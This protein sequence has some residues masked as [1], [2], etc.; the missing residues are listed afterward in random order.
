MGLKDIYLKIE[1][2]WFDLLDFLD[3][4]GLPVYTAIDPLEK[5]GIPSLP[6]FLS[7]LIVIILLANILFMGN[8]VV[9]F[10]ITNQKGE[11]IPATLTLYDDNLNEINTLVTNNG[12]V[13]LK[14]KQGSYFFSIDSSNCTSLINKN[15]DVNEKEQLKELNLTCEG[16]SLSSDEKSYCLDPTET[17][18]AYLKKYENGNFINKEFCGVD[19]CA[20]RAT[21]GYD[22]KVVTEDYESSLLTYNK[23]MDLSDSGD[24]IKLNKKQIIPKNPQPVS[25][26]VKNEEGLLL[27]YASIQ[28]VNPDNENSVLFE[29]ITNENGSKRF[30]NIELGTKFQVKVL[31]TNNTLTYLAPKKYETPLGGLDITITLNLSASSKI[32]VQEQT[33]SGRVNSRDAFITLIDPELK[34]VENMKRTNINGTTTFGVRKDKEYKVGVW[35]NGFEPKEIEIKG[36]E[37]AEIVIQPVLKD[38]IG[39]IEVKTTLEKEKLGRGAKVILNTPDEI[40]VGIPP[41]TTDSNGYANFNYITPGSYCIKAYRQNGEES[42]CEPVEVTAGEKSL[43]EINFE[44][45]LYPINLNIT[46]KNQKPLDEADISIIDEDGNEI[47][48]CSGKSIDGEFSCEVKESTK[49]TV[50]AYYEEGGKKYAARTQL[51]EI[52]KETNADII[53][54]EITTKITILGVVKQGDDEKKDEFV[55]LS[56]KALEAGSSIYTL[57]LSVGTPAYADSLFNKISFKITEDSGTFEFY[58]GEKLGGFEAQEKDEV[59]STRTYKLENKKYQVGTQ[60]I[61]IPFRIKSTNAETGTY[62]IKAKA[63]WVAPNGK[64]F[65]YPDNLGYVKKEVNVTAK[66]CD[67]I[68]EFDVCY[69]VKQGDNW[70]NPLIETS[71]SK[72]V[73][74]KVQAKVEITNEGND[75]FDGTINLEDENNISKFNPDETVITVPQGSLETGRDFTFSNNLYS[76][77]INNQNNFKLK[78]G[79][80]I[81]INFNTSVLIKPGETR[82]KINIGGTEQKTNLKFLITGQQQATLVIDEDKIYDLS[83]SINFHLEDVE[84]NKISVYDYT[85]EQSYLTGGIEG[86]NIELS[87]YNT[88]ISIDNENNEVTVNFNS[89]RYLLGNSQLKFIIAGTTLQTINE[90]KDIESC[91]DPIA[92]QPIFV[93]QDTTCRFYINEDTS[94]SLKPETEDTD[95]CD[96]DNYWTLSFKS[97][98]DAELKPKKTTVEVT[99]QEEDSEGI[100]IIYEDFLESPPSFVF[101]FGKQNADNNDYNRNL[102]IT[103]IFENDVG[104]RKE[105][106]TEF[107]L[108]LTKRNNNLINKNEEGYFKA[109]PT[110]SYYDPDCSSNYCT[111]EQFLKFIKP[112]LD[113][114]DNFGNSKI[115]NVNLIT[116]RQALLNLNELR[117]LT[118]NITGLTTSIGTPDS[119]TATSGSHEIFINANAAATTSGEI[120]GGLNQIVIRRNKNAGAYYI[121]TIKNINPILAG[122]IEEIQMQMPYTE[123]T[124]LTDSTLFNKIS[125]NYEIQ[126]P[127]TTLTPRQKK[128]IGNLFERL[129]NALYSYNPDELERYTLQATGEVV[130]ISGTSVTKNPNSINK[131]ILGVCPDPASSTDITTLCGK[132]NVYSGEQQGY[133]GIIIK[134]FLDDKNVY[135][136][137]RTADDLKN[138]IGEFMN[139]VIDKR[140][141]S[142]TS[143]GLKIYSEVSCTDQAEEDDCSPDSNSYINSSFLART[144]SIVKVYC[145]SSISCELENENNELTNAIKE[146]EANALNYGKNE[147]TLIPKDSWD[148]ADLA[149][150]SKDDS[151]Y[152]TIKTEFQAMI[153]WSNLIPP[154]GY[155]FNSPKENTIILANSKDTAEKTLE[156]KGAPEQETMKSMNSKL[157]D[158]ISNAEAE[159]GKN[160]SAYVNITDTDNCIISMKNYEDTI[161]QGTINI[162]YN[163]DCKEEFESSNWITEDGE[164]KLI[165]GEYLITVSNT[166]T[167]SE[168]GT[169]SDK[170][171]KVYL[172][173]LKDYD[174]TKASTLTENGYCETQKELKPTVPV[175]SITLAELI[176]KI[177]EG[178]TG[179]YL[180]PYYITD[181]EIKITNLNDGQSDTGVLSGLGNWYTN[182]DDWTRG[183][184][185]N[186]PICDIG[187]DWDDR[188]DIGTGIADYGGTSQWEVTSW[189]LDGNEIHTTTPSPMTNSYCLYENSGTTAHKGDIVNVF[190]SDKDASKSQNIIGIGLET[191]HIENITIT[192]D[193]NICPEGYSFEPS[194]DGGICKQITTEES[195]QP[196]ATINTLSILAKGSYCKTSNKHPNK[197]EDEKENELAKWNT[198]ECGSYKVGGY[199]YI[200][201]CREDYTCV[202]KATKKGGGKCCPVD[203]PNYDTTNHMCCPD[204]TNYDSSTGNCISSSS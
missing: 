110:T 142:V 89:D 131:I 135:F 173:T 124:G 43:V 113:D 126:D 75:D 100:G 164:S 60:E 136:I 11:S 169:D 122:S 165:P 18:N 183:I 128:E 25:V 147:I 199:D 2:K 200:Y 121:E 99:K 160:I 146:Y 192:K 9:Q 133:N 179:D 85:G 73:G 83:N 114:F 107:G 82:Y 152:N 78:H 154:E 35:K 51:G 194:D 134:D 86:G 93:W 171:Y 30:K 70:I 153:G 44:K 188:G 66:Q 125:L 151:N 138:L 57:V 156:N 14:V 87:Y 67:V 201:H 162:C 191:L 39:A 53:L 190:I 31:G 129:I 94:S 127:D 90:T 117:E 132:F 13:E 24:C 76:M 37:D 166:G 4:K 119:S 72:N 178:N 144:P 170:T 63:E 45:T 159:E 181:D 62:E 140:T 29:G 91:I 176:Q 17:G 186:S 180:G 68:D 79:G 23:L 50:I 105:V 40:P 187:N 21:E 81:N 6:V 19:A 195:E 167:D 12:T 196:A 42:E 141:Q 143:S 155:I 157:K 88:L 10:S 123:L 174:S 202:E 80:T 182:C 54:T 168:T 145:S 95:Y 77:E 69:S 104:V 32:K 120:R 177:W 15:L 5:K 193:D 84:G 49:A 111:L 27:S 116:N 46:D 61:H 198:A 71:I 38:K 158:M 22:Y 16:A 97:K 59:L 41:A 161:G 36:G 115:Y 184:I 64:T 108:I 47:P 55:N 118:Q 33:V 101:D 65:N 28:L 197:C 150:I 102:R 58:A 148:E 106:I 149:I 96:A 92:T 189:S 137:G 48:E 109:L 139:A 3:D 56:E 130:S 34:K 52:I 7:S 175:T 98:C 163:D 74:D 1:D 8:A 20:I 103:T 185:A 112:D 26:T 203:Y 204:G 172:K